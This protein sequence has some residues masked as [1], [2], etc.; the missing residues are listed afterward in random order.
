LLAIGIVCLTAIYT[1]P[2]MLERGW[3]SP[4]AW[5]RIEWM[6]ALELELCSFFMLKEDLTRG[7]SLNK[8]PLRYTWRPA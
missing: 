3:G 8:L 6:V 1:A 5:R 7:R 4:R 2:L